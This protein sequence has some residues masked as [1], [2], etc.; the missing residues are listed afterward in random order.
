MALCWG[1]SL[2]QSDGLTP[3]RTGDRA[4]F[5]GLPLT[6]MAAIGHGSSCAE[7]PS[8]SPIGGAPFP[9][10][11][12]VHHAQGRNQAVAAQAT[13]FRAG[14]MG[15]LRVCRSRRLRSQYG[16]VPACQY[17]KARGPAECK[18]AGRRRG[19]DS[20]AA[21][22]T[23]TPIDVPAIEADGASLIVMKR[24]GIHVPVDIRGLAILT[25]P[26]VP[27]FELHD[28]GDLS[29]QTE[30]PEALAALY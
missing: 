18:K 17:F 12:A 27:V 15:T 23:S 16:R 1:N 20:A 22:P 3:G 6:M 13:V 11:S 7:M 5:R 19:G 8:I 25:A 28:L 2:N 30:L 26:F 24:N 9:Q 14:E 10:H 29:A 21:R 4:A